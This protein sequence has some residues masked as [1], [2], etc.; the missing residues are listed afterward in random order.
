MHKVIF[1]TAWSSQGVRKT[2]F[3]QL[4]RSLAAHLDYEVG[5][6]LKVQGAYAFEMRKDGKVVKIGL[7]TAY[8]RWLN[9]ATAMAERVDEVWVAAFLWADEQTPTHVQVYRIAAEDLLEKFAKVDESRKAAGSPNAFAYI[10][11]DAVGLEVANKVYNKAAG[12]VLDTATLLFEAP[13]IFRDD[14][15]ARVIA[16]GAP[17]ASSDESPARTRPSAVDV[18]VFR[19]AK[20]LVADALQIDPDMVTI[21]V[22][23]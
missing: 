17:I 10:P 8:E 13:L 18:D 3:G 16:A 12:F 15:D 21:K 2:A 19:R 5:N 23:V 20:Q 9:T 6:S 11:L 7:K 22:T 1:P 4:F 14:G